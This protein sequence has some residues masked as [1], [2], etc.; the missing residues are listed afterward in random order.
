[1][2]WREFDVTRRIAT[3]P[4][5]A[6]DFVA[7]YR[8]VPRVLEGVSRWEPLSKQARGEGARFEVEMRTFGIPLANV[9]VL[10]AWEPGR[11]IG[12]RS[13]SGLVEQRGGWTFEA[14]RPQLTEV[15]LAI[16]YRPP[17]AALGNLLAG[18]VDSL[19]RARLARALESMASLLEREPA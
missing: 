14:L 18:R 2:G 13:E 4:A 17:G 12:W 7:D 19:V 6:F 8:N 10:V 11:R 15:T 9:L 1:M 3:S 5:R 16:S